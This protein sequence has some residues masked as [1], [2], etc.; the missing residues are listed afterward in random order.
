MT[1]RDE[2]R[3][4][5]RLKARDERAFRELVEL[6]QDMVYNLVFR[7]LGDREEARDVSQEVFVTVFKSIHTFRGDSQ[8]STWLYRVT[9]NHAKNRI[10][11]LARRGRERRQSLDDT[12]DGELHRA[13]ADPGPSPVGVAVG[14][15]LE[16]M[17]Q[18]ALAALDEEQRL[19]I[20]LRDIENLSYEEISAITHLAMGTVKSRLHRARAALRVALER[21]ETRRR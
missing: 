9:A 12:T 19:V 15:E 13:G 2:K 18:R 20:V 3:L 5:R 10:K 4:L 17:I 16:G 8:L 6:H 21:E 11:Y 1:P 7:M 14:R